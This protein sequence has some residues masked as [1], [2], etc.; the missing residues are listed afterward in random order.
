[1]ATA[2]AEGFRI[3]RDPERRTTT[4]SMEVDVSLEQEALKLEETAEQLDAVARL[5]D[6]P[7]NEANIMSVNGYEYIRTRYV[8]ERARAVFASQDVEF[9]SKIARHFL[10]T[11]GSGDERIQFAFVHHRAEAMQ[12]TR[13]NIGVSCTLKD[14]TTFARGKALRRTMRMFGRHLDIPPSIPIDNDEIFGKPL[15]VW[16]Y[17]RS[18][19]PEEEEKEVKRFL[20]L[21]P[22]APYVTESAG[23]KYYVKLQHTI[24]LA[25]RI[26]GPAG[27]SCMLEKL[28]LT[29]SDPDDGWL[30][31][32]A[33]MHVRL[34]VFAV[35]HS[36]KTRGKFKLT[37]K[38]HQ[39][40][41][42]V[43]KVYTI[44]VSNLFA[45]FGFGQMPQEGD[46]QPPDFSL[47][48]TPTPPNLTTPKRREPDTGH[49][50]S[51]NPG[52]TPKT[53]HMQTT[54]ASASGTSP[55]PGQTPNTPELALAYVRQI[56]FRGLQDKE[57]AKAA[58]IS[59]HLPTTPAAAPS[60]VRVHVPQTPPRSPPQ[61]P[62]G[63]RR[64]LTLD[65][66]LHVPR[67]DDE[68]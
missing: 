67:S 56:F 48:P 28:E 62:K 53:S 10:W 36:Q 11:F 9:H 38:P 6:S 64:R 37:C 50:S 20:E 34:Q 3:T 60:P 63:S 42:L 18:S 54:P 32:D 1:M 2:Y 16:M 44:L 15:P 59:R 24:L 12:C 17:S 8:N 65:E 68:E 61:S 30:S 40:S 19:S 29:L 39:A 26:F 45:H 23:K 52:K 58:A 5:L 51:P 27:W 14:C 43:M 57:R 47:Q 41:D 55:H 46:E 49:S 7:P 25:N 31:M 13:D 22:V 4:F 35:G 66:I 21:V 33:V